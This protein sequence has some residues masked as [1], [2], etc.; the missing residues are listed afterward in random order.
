LTLADYTN[1]TG[2]LDRL[3]ALPAWADPW[4]ARAVS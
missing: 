3:M 1:V 2:W 4:P